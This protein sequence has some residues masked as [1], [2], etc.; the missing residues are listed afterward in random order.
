MTTR[1]QEQAVDLDLLTRAQLA[2][3]PHLPWADIASTLDELLAREH[4]L[5]SSAHGVGLFV[6]LLAER[7]WQVTRLPEPVTPLLPPP[8]E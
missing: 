3:M 1:P 5:F 7:G 2:E 4:G 8:T 6:E